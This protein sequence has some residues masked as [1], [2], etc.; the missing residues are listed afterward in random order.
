MK[1]APAAF[2]V[3]FLELP[4]HSVP[5][6]PPEGGLAHVG[7]AEVEAPHLRAL[8]QDAANVGVGQAAAARQ[9]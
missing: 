4:E 5:V 1:T 7:V 8:P 9:H 6:Q 3:E 2:Q